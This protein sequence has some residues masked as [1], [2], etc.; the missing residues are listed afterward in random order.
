MKETQSGIA[1][2]GGGRVQSQRR[3]SS[4]LHGNGMVPSTFTRFSPQQHV[5]EGGIRTRPTVDR[6]PRGTPRQAAQGDAPQLGST[7][8]LQDINGRRHAPPALF[9]NLGAHAAL[10]AN[11]SL[12]CRM[13]PKRQGPGQV[14]D[15]KIYLYRQTETWSVFG[16]G[17]RRLC[18]RP[19]ETGSFDARA[20]SAGVAGWDADR[21]RELEGSSAFQNIK[22]TKKSLAVEIAPRQLVRVEGL[23]GRML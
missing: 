1:L 13:E 18:A 23:D 4:G 20:R 3:S 5:T 16:R 10:S 11:S 9:D 22:R 2:P 21:G 19:C 6:T 12:K 14:P 7:I 15:C 17:A 8:D